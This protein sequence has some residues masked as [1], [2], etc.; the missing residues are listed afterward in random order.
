MNKTGVL[1]AFLAWC[2]AFSLYGGTFPVPTEQVQG[3]SE[4]DT[5]SIS[6]PGWAA[7]DGDTETG[8]RLGEG[9]TEG[10]ILQ[11]WNSPKHI[12]ELVLTAEIPEGSEISVYAA[13]GRNKFRGNLIPVSAGIVRG[14]VFGDITLSFPKWGRSCLSAISLYV[15]LASN[16]TIS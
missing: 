16:I 6:D 1:A 13:E 12:K 4:S 7:F 3:V 14:P 9:E 10:W 11:S 5:T 2:M 15:C 8:W